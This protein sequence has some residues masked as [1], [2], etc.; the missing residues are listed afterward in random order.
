MSPTDNQNEFV[1][2]EEQPKPELP[3]LDFTAEDVAAV[4]AEAAAMEAAEPKPGVCPLCG[5][6]PRDK[7]RCDSCGVMVTH[8]GSGVPDVVGDKEKPRMIAGHTRAELLQMLKEEDK[9]Q[10]E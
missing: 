7:Q 4:A 1:S 3:P 10:Q 9:R 2:F 6:E 5:R 8:T